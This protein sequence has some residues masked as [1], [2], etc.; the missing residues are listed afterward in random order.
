M[1]YSS[2]GRI[3]VVDDEPANVEVFR[4]L[5]ILQGYDVLTASDGGS[6]LT[7]AARDRPDLVLLDVNMPGIDGF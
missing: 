6:A 5:M 3:L 1:R 4:R 2:P 7:I